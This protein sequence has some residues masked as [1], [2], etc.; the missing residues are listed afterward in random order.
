MHA[1]RQSA[2]LCDIVHAWWLTQ[3]RLTISLFNCTPAGRASDEMKA[4]A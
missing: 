1:V 3:S 4:T 2:C